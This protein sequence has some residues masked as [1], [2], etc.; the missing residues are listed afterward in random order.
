M[1]ALVVTA[2]RAVDA[3]ADAVYRY[4]AD[5]REHH[6][7]F[8]PPAFSD[9]QVESGGVGAGTIV[10]FTLTAGGRSR[11]SRVQIAEPEPGRILSESGIDSSQVTTFRV[12]P[13]GSTSRVLISSTWKGASGIGGFFERMFAPRVLRGILAD[14]LQ[15]LDAYARE[16]SSAS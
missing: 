13:Q 16:Q 1:A 5:Y 7:K 3:P 10:H 15:R 8:L 2:D 14:E 6:P 12:T 9:Y 11:V 4:I